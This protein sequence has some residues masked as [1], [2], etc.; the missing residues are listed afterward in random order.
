MNWLQ[1]AN[2]PILKGRIVEFSK[3]DR[4]HLFAIDG[5]S[6]P[7]WKER[8]FLMCRGGKKRGS[9]GSE[10]PLE[11]PVGLISRVLSSHFQ[12][13]KEPAVTSTAQ[14]HVYS[15]SHRARARRFNETLH[16]LSHL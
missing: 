3:D 13:P 9:D 14:D 8:I 5:E 10:P 11:A 4:W 6:K 15:R 16:H 7:D 2:V 12:H 1:R